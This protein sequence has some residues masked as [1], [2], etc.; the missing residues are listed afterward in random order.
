MRVDSQVAIYT[1]VRFLLLVIIPEPSFRIENICVFAENLLI[2]VLAVTIIH[3]GMTETNERAKKGNT[4]LE[5]QQ[6]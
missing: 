2:P 4:I 5:H 1:N 3:I 6:S